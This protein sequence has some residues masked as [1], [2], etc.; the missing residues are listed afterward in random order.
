LIET[1][2]GAESELLEGSEGKLTGKWYR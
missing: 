2:D 1:E